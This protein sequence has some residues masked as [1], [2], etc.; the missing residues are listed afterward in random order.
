MKRFLALCLCVILVIFSL[1]ACAPELHERLLIRAIGIDD[2][3]HGWRVTIRAAQADESE[4]EICFTEEGETVSAALEKIAQNT[5][6]KPLYSH[7][8]LIVFGRSCAEQGLSGCLD[9]FL[10]HYDSR[11]TVKVV[12]ADDTAEVL[13]TH[14]DVSAD[15]ITALLKSEAYSGTTVDADL[16]A[17]IN[18]T[19]GAN[20]STVLPI[21]QSEEAIQF[22]G[23]G[24]LKG[25]RLCADLDHDALRGYLALTEKLKS[26]ETVFEDD[27]C[28]TVSVSTND[29][30]CSI[31]FT[32]TRENPRFTAEVTIGGE[33]SSISGGIRRL[34]SSAF[35]QLEKEYAAAIL[36]D[37]DAYLQ[38]AV[39]ETDC[40]AAGFG[41]AV[42]RAEPVLWHEVSGSFAEFLKRSVFD[43][44]V[45]AQIERVEEED[46]PYL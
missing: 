6:K 22:S 18:G 24:I 5:G 43:I 3:E 20:G 26:G 7:N 39:F 29:C 27:L 45:T 9:F 37:I 30:A 23:A 16:I 2:L 32:G 33:I 46:T 31:R 35:P 12:L 17:L 1:S 38:A 42:L 44:Q 34:E 25:M 15:G 36:G 10:R 28:G 13:L 11:P 8:A 40:D 41:N 21:I 14:P 19:F 4:K